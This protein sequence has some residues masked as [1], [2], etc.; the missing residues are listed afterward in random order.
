MQRQAKMEVSTKKSLFQRLRRNE[1]GLAIIEF[2]FSMPILMGLGM[3]GSE[4]SFLAISNMKISQAALNL[5]DN[6]SRIGQ[7]NNGVVNPTILESNINEVFLGAALQAGQLNLLENGRVALSSLEVDTSTDPD[8]QFISWQR[9]KGLL[10][11]RTDEEKADDKDYGSSYDDDADDDGSV[12]PTFTGMGSNGTN[13]RAVEDSAVMVVEIEY[14]YQ[15]LFG[16]LFLPE[17]TIRQEAAFNIRDDRNLAA[18]LFN[19]MGANA[20]NCNDFTAS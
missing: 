2:A 3:Y 1:S 13:L 12:D 17:K 9:C 15:P 10:D 5:A 14:T 19:D 7:T 11:R 16:D 8:Q 20:A 6:A 4:L 18:G